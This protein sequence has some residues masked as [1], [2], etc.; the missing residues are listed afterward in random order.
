MAL[1]PCDC[2][3]PPVRHC[4]NLSSK[5]AL[6]FVVWRPSLCLLFVLLEVVPRSAP[7]WTICRAVTHLALHGSHA[8]VQDRACSQSRHNGDSEVQA[9]WTFT[10]DDRE[11]QHCCTLLEAKPACSKG[12]VHTLRLLIMTAALPFPALCVDDV[13]EVCRL[14][15]DNVHLGFFPEPGH[16]NRQQQ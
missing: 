13:V 11:S 12:A 1:K 8:I 5:L 14:G 7:A 2:T 16:A 9:Y 4:L 10:A 6:V 15:Q 3:R